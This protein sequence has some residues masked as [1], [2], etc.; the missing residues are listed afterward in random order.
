MAGLAEA[1]CYWKPFLAICID[2]AGFCQGPHHPRPFAVA[3][4]FYVAAK[5]ERLMIQL[6]NSMM[7]HR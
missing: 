5:S 4:I 2:K 6:F 7:C 1:F 3:S